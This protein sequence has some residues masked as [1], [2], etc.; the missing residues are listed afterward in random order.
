M[1]QPAKPLWWKLNR[2]TV[3]REGWTSAKSIIAF[4]ALLHEPDVYKYTSTVQVEESSCAHTHT[5]KRR[6][7]KAIRSHS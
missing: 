4:K 1:E 2:S 3:S 6:T 5:S 7:N